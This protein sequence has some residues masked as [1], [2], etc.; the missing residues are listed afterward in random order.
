MNTHWCQAWL[1]YGW[2]WLC[3]WV[4]QP[5]IQLSLW[6]ILAAGISIPVSLRTRQ[7][8]W[9]LAL[10]LCMSIAF[11][12]VW[13]LTRYWL[14]L[15]PY[16]I[17]LT[18]LVSIVLIGLAA[19]WQVYLIEQSACLDSHGTAAWGTLAEHESLENGFCLGELDG[20]RFI[21][22]G[23]VLTCAPTGSGKGVGA[24]IPNLMDYPGSVFV[25]DVK[26][27]NYAVTH[28]AR[29][30]HIVLI[31]PYGVTG[32]PSASINWLSHLDVDSP[33]AIQEASLLADMLVLGGESTYWDDAA[34]DLLRGLIL[35]VASMQN[36]HMGRLREI[37]SSSSPQLQE[38]LNDMVVSRHPIVVRTANTFMAKADKDRSGVLSS[39]NRHTSFLDDTRLVNCLTQ[40]DL[41]LQQLRE[42]RTSVYLVIPPAML[43][44]SKRFI[45]GLMGLT[46]SRL[47]QVAEKP[48]VDTAFFL[49][50]FAQLGYMAN[51]EEAISLVRGYGIRFW[52][53]VQD[54]SQL[55]AVYPKWQTFLA[56][57]T[58]QCFGTADVD[59]ARYLSQTLGDTTVLYA[60]SGRHQDDVR[61]LGSQNTNEVRTS[62]ALLTPDEVMRLDKGKAIVLVGGE[63]PYLVN[64][65]N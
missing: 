7:F 53:L 17:L 45:R 50:E 9:L 26:G 52:I 6:V 25:L 20:Q 28:R 16:Q 1:I 59:T 11:S 63:K 48:N 3:W 51:I 64:R 57:T 33:A 8:V 41:D 29:G 10:P 2:Q 40:S 58:K 24:V 14:V 18:G 30:G 43:S 21:Q 13:L 23:H 61:L 12:L 42:T 65:L 56:N 31:D 47:T 37:V 39:A 32:Q 36:P 49:D 60:S 62:R 4:S 22:G 19:Q 15:S 35:Y 54:L 27:E 55:K 38:I 44:T 46:L 5:L 34:K